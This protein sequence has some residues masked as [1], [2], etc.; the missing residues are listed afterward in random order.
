MTDEFRKRARNFLLL[1]IETVAAFDSYEKL[2]ERM[3]RLWD[4]KAVSLKR[5]DDSLTN[6]EYF[7]DRGAIYSE[8]GKIVCIAFGGFYWNENDEIAFKVSSFSGDDEV[9]LLNQ[10]KALIEK[11]PADQLILCAHN[12]KEFDFPFLC[13]RCSF[14]VLKSQKP[15]RLQ[16]KN[17]G[18]SCT[19]IRWTCG[20]L[21]ITRVILRSICWLRFLTFPVV[22]LK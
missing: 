9:L 8:F 1:D 17:P 4:K 15:Y 21:V 12:G 22:K 19:R 20:S 16:V 14:T 6:A 18:K 5:G 7:Y 3:Q 13:R 11:Y 2:P 10:F